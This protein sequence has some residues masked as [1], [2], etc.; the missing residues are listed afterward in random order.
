V[1]DLSRDSNDQIIVGMTLS[2][3]NP[4]TLGASS[5]EVSGAILKELTKK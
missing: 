1:Y 3:D 2:V 4:E 5:I